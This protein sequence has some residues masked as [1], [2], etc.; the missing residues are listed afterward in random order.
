MKYKTSMLIISTIL[1]IACGNKKVS[2]DLDCPTTVCTSW[3]TGDKRNYYVKLIHIKYH[4]TMS[5]LISVV[6]LS[7][8]NVEDTPLHPLLRLNTIL[9]HLI[10]TSVADLSYHNVETTPLHPLKVKQVHFLITIKN[11]L[12][13]DP[14]YLRAHF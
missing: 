8:L 4:N 6:D 12:I 11:I 13:V 14:K 10:F 2:E 1:C 3:I 5:N 9:Q 7:Y